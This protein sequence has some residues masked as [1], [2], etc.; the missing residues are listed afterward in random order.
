[1]LT[2]NGFFFFNRGFMYSLAE[3]T[4]YIEVTRVIGNPDGAIL[5]V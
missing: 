1:M 5:A 3:M 2:A 4:S